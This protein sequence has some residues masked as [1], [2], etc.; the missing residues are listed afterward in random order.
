MK[1]AQITKIDF[2]KFKMIDSL[3]P[4]TVFDSFY[5]CFSCILSSYIVC[6]YSISWI[7]KSTVGWTLLVFAFLV[8]SIVCFS[9]HYFS[10]ICRISFSHSLTWQNRSS[11]VL[12]QVFILLLFKY[13]W[14]ESWWSLKAV[15]WLI[16]MFYCWLSTKLFT[17]N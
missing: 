17:I 11:Y 10:R 6:Q 12:V 13:F 8:I 7:F 3:R 14:S 2:I 1:I 5:L 4:S 16:L 15:S 9:H